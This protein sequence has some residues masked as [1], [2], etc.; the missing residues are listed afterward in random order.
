MDVRMPTFLTTISSD[1]PSIC[2]WVIK[3]DMISVQ[4]SSTPARDDMIGN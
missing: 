2:G 4:N 1:I 3:R